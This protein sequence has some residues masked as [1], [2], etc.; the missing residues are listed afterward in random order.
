MNKYDEIIADIE[1]KI[2]TGHFPAG[3][4]LPSI[5]SAAQQYGYN[6]ST[7]IRAYAELERRH[8]IYSMP[9][10][11]YYVVSKQTTPVLPADAAEH[12]DFSSASP[13]L[14]T[15]PYLDFQH[16]L[17][18][19]IDIHKHQ[20]FTYSDTRGLGTLRTALVSHLANDQ[21]FTKA[22]QIMITSG[23]QQA[24]MI[25]ARMPF[26]NGKSVIL[27][28]QPSYDIYLRYLEIEQL[29]VKGIKRSANGIDLEEL[30][31]RFKDGNIKFFYTMS[32][33]HNPLGISFRLEERQAI[34]DL[35]C[36]YDVYVVEDDYMSDLGIERKF[37]P[38][39]AYDPSGH[40]IYLKSYS[41][42]IF[43]GVR[44]GVAVLPEPLFE[45]F[46]TH[47]RFADLNTSSLSQ[48]A[49]EIYIKNRMFER[50]KH[51]ISELY[52]ERMKT[53]NEALAYYNDVDE[54]EPV[55][56][57]S[58]VYMHLKLPRRIP[59]E[60]LI[61]KLAARNVIAVPSEGFY[62]REAP[63]RDKFLRLS[64]SRVPSEQMDIGVR[65]IIEEIK[66]SLHRKSVSFVTTKK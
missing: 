58:G 13:E 18:K 39:Y 42:I 33:Y 59:I 8:S 34:A 23:A 43:P 9:Q 22:D 12:I 56:V 27:V 63:E 16:C 46:H 37:D 10:S 15:F 45:T 31:K 65:A 35:A 25:L 36:K 29:P 62:L 55:M 30:E 17:N 40:V 6:R 44:L 41:K 60:T 53:L 32:R 14:N 48:A 20:L 54:V 64:I 24:L 61:R 38:I 5:R 50:H 52:T 28:E 49:L 19:A 26:P 4:K 47:K 7:I 11:G 57:Q 1:E 2:R 66:Q 21:V 51:K 3:H